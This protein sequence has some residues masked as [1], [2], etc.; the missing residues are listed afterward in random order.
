MVIYQKGLPYVDVFDN[1][2]PLFFQ[3]ASLFHPLGPWGLWLMISLILLAVALLVYFIARNVIGDKAALISLLFIFSMH[4][5][6]LYQT[7]A[8]TRTV[9]GALL[10]FSFILLSLNGVFWKNFLLGFNAATIFLYLPIELLTIAPIAIYGLLSQNHSKAFTFKTAP[11]IKNL[12]YQLL[13]ISVVFVPSAYY[14]LDHHLMA[15]FWRDAFAFNFDIYLREIS[16]KAKINS[17]LL[18]FFNYKAIFLSL[19]VYLGLLHFLFAYRQLKEKKLFVLAFLLTGIQVYNTLKSGLVFYY[20]L[21]SFVPL[22]SIFFFLLINEYKSTSWLNAMTNKLKLILLCGIISYS[23]YR[24]YNNKLGFKLP[25]FVTKIEEVAHQK[26]QLYVF[27]NTRYIA[28][29][30]QLNIIAPSRHIFTHQWNRRPYY[31]QDGKIFD[32]ILDDIEKYKTKY[33]VDFSD[34][35]PINRKMLQMKWNRLIEQNYVKIDQDTVIGAVLYQR[36]ATK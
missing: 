16:I 25:D 26:G 30:T 20:Y 2:P 3:M 32:S 4:F 12:L 10:F 35:R 7:T 29:N 22:S 19:P 1:K 23:V 6:A 9:T 13:G 27:R 31:D 5:I 14:L 28:I 33:I 17:F 34:K 36:K 15:V 24:F 8:E 21:Y 11:I 18:L